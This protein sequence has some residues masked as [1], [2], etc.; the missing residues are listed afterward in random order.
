M[1]FSDKEKRKTYLRGRGIFP[2][3]IPIPLIIDHIHVYVIDGPTPI[4]IDTGF[5]GDECFAALAQGL[6]GY[7]RDVA[8]IGVILLTHG[9]RDHSGL[10]RAIR[11]VSGAR[12]HLHR[13]DVPI[14]APNSF[15]GY[16]ERVLDYYRDMGVGPDR[17]NAALSLSAAERDRYRDRIGLDDSTLV[18]G[19]LSSGDR[20]ETGAGVLSVIETP[21]HTTGSVSLFFEEDSILFSGDLIS[22]AYDP[23][24][25]VLAERDGDGWLNTY[26]DHLA[27]LERLSGLDP[28]LVLPGHGGPISQGQR[29]VKRIMSVQ[30]RLTARIEEAVHARRGQ[31][32][33]AL[34]ESIY[35]RVYGPALTTALN[36]V[37]GISKRLARE[38]KIQIDGGHI[39]RPGM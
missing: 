18:D 36:V 21:G 28:A 25:L 4:L 30:E 5:F 27:S 26:D 38:G 33:A 9:H 17:V 24:P 11:E 19:D 20:F 13:P 7:G 35:P 1:D 23:L 15:F 6:S 12:I 8:D 16:F 31:T 14:M 22:V 2:I 39:V 29:L 32:I 10:A 3:R 34:T 37:R